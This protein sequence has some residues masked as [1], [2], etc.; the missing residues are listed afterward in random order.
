MRDFITYIRYMFACHQAF[1]K[2]RTYLQYFRL[3]SFNCPIVSV[4]VSTPR[5]PVT[6]EDLIE[7]S[8]AVIEVEYET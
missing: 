6:I 2:S 7:N 5:N 3:V 4:L 8:G 1:S